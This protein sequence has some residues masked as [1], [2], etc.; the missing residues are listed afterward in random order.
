MDAS[1]EGAM[2]RNRS[3]RQAFVIALAFIVLVGIIFSVTMNKMPTTDDFLK[4]WAAVGPIV[5][6]VTG[7]IPTYFFRDMADDAS[8][9][10][11]ANARDMGAMM[12][13]LRE[14]KIDPAQYLGGRD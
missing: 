11:E 7:L 4:V 1:K 12:G 14:M 10:A 8:R 3:R 13:K 5:G 6:V 9:R 2:E